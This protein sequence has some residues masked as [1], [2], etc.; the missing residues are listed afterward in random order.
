MDEKNEKNKKNYVIN[1]N[2]KELLIKILLYQKEYEFINNNNEI[3][4][5][6]KIKIKI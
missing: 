4:L 2:E 5:F 3:Y 6:Y 1:K